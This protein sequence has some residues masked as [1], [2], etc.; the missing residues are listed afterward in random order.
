VR[1][2]EDEIREVV[3]EVVRRVLT[4]SLQQPSVYYSPWT[5]VEYQAHPSNLQFNINEATHSSGQLQEFSETN[6]CSIENDRPC[7]HCGMCRSL[8]F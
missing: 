5:G 8:G 2:K 7:D 6:Q 3:R 1:S 4:E